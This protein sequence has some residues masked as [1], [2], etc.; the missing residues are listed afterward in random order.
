M[1]VKEMEKKEAVGGRVEKRMLCFCGAHCPVS[2]PTGRPNA[3]P[4]E[5]AGSS[6]YAEKVVGVI[7]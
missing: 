1:L 5:V 2:T 7:L 6:G 3:G 4:G